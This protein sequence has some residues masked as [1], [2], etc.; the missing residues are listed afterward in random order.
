MRLNIRTDQML[1]PDSVSI[2][3]DSKTTELPSIRT[4][5]LIRVSQINY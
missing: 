1:Q 5:L 4:G 3:S 2:D